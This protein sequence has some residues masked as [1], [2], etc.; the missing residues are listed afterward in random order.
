M[1]VIAASLTYQQTGTTTICRLR[2]ELEIFKGTVS[3][4][5]V[6][7]LLKDC[8]FEVIQ[9]DSLIILKII[10]NFNEIITIYPPQPSCFK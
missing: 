10:I 9:V 4:T 5:A 8:L 7:L 6:V 1:G 3:P 2:P